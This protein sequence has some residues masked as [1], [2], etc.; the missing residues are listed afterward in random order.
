MADWQP[1]MISV[2]IH[3]C[4]KRMSKVA[5]YVAQRKVFGI[6]GHAYIMPM[7]CCCWL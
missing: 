5:F 1:F 2:V 7:S 3:F 4:K 6:P